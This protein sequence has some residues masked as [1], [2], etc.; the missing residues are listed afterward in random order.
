MVLIIVAVTVAV[1]VSGATVRVA[2]C[3]GHFQAVSMKDRSHPGKEKNL[4]LLL[5]PGRFLISVVKF[6]CNCFK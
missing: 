6:P 2:V 5:I 4:I 3:E 1:I